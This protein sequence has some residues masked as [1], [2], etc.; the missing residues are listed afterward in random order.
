MDRENDVADELVYLDGKINED[1]ARMVT[2]LT[3]E[4][5]VL[6]DRLMVLEHLL[7]SQGVVA[8]GQ[9]DEFVPDDELTANLQAEREALVAR[10]I[11]APH[12]KDITVE[13]L[14]AKGHR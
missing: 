4:V 1:L 14:V 7:A 2:E 8:Q 12:N 9:L 11:G 3:S 13:G 6:R 10:V 5:W